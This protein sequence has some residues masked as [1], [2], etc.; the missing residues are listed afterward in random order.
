MRSVFYA[1]AFLALALVLAPVAAADALR[2]LWR[3]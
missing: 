3:R 1:F 2:E